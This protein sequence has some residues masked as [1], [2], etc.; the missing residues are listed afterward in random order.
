MPQ[1]IKTKPAL[2]QK[3]GSAKNSVQTSHTGKLGG[4]SH[5]VP[6]VTKGHVASTLNERVLDSRDTSQSK[7]EG[8]VVT[9]TA[10]DKL[11]H[12]WHTLP[13]YLKIFQINGKIEQKFHQYDNADLRSS[14]SFGF[15]IPELTLGDISPYASDSSDDTTDDDIEEIEAKHHQ[16]EYERGLRFTH[17]SRR[18]T[19]SSPVQDESESHKARSTHEA[20]SLDGDVNSPPTSILLQEL[21]LS[22][23]EER[24]EWFDYD[25]NS[26]TWTTKPVVFRKTSLGNAATPTHLSV[27]E[28]G[29]SR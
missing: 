25:P 28:H 1:L 17:H 13:Q 12:Q 23:K 16:V 26:N 14:P 20:R 27:R 24:A 5:G 11:L 7:H 21:L 8:T 22:A 15:E 4:D 19:L 18:A 29:S 9:V 10:A 2:L 3:P 6:P